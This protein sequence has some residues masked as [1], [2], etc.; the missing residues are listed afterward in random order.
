MIKPPSKAQ[1]NMMKQKILEQNH[2]A[3]FLVSKNS[4]EQKDFLNT[5]EELSTSQ[6]ISS[7]NQEYFR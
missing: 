6:S 5:S 1:E 4:E 2:I 3:P 7:I